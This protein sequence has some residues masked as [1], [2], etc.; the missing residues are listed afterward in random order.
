MKTLNLWTLFLTISICYFSSLTIVSCSSDPDSVNT[1]SAVEQNTE[2]NASVLRVTGTYPENAS[3]AYDIAG[4]LYYDI[5]ESY[6][7]GAL[8]STSTFGTIQQVESIANNNLEY[9]ALKPASYVSPTASRIDY[10]VANPDQSKLDIIS[11]S[12]MSIKAKLSLSDFLD[13]L[14]LYRD[15]KKSYDFIYQFIIGYE[16]GVV[17]DGSYNVNDKMVILTTTSISRYSFYFASKH[18]RRPRDRDWDISWGNIVGG[19]EG[20]AESTA[21]AIVMSTVAGL[22]T[23]R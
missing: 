3:N 8:L 15:Q 7:T 9:Q 11:N 1:S 18:R 21:K 22:I 19:T 4:Q 20:S 2:A 12:S 14:M 23:N 17:A 10:I 5:S 6:Y 16:N 13:T